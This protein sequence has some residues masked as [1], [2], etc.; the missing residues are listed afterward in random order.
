MEEF[1]PGQ[2]EAVETVLAGRDLFALFPTGAGKSLC[3]QLPALILPPPTLVISPLIALMR[4]QVA[5]L[6]ARGIGAVCLDSLQPPEVF[7]EGMAAVREGRARL[8]YVS[9]ERL[10]SRR[11][12]ALMA[13]CPPSLAVVDEAHCC[14]Q[15]GEGFRPA[16]A[17]IGAFIRA[18]ARRPVV[19][20]MTATADRRLR[21]GI[22]RSVGLRRPRLLRLPLIRENLRYAV[23]TTSDPT[24]EALRVA[25]AHE[26]ERGVV[27]CGTRARCE[28]LSAAL[29]GAGIAAERYHAGLDRGER[30]RVQEAF[31]AREVTV[32]AAT[33][34][35]GMGVDIPD[36]RWVLHDR[37]PESVTDYAQQSGRAGR[38]GLE[39][40]CILLVDPADLIRRSAAF[41]HA[42][43]ELKRLPLWRTSE[44]VRE[45]LRLRT[46]MAESRAMA[47][48]ALNG[49]CIPQQ[50]AAH[51]GAKARPCGLCSACVRRE[52]LG[53]RQ[54][55]AATPDIGR[56]TPD[57][58]RLWALDW[59][60]SAIAARLGTTPRDVLTDEGMAF[61]AEHRTLCPGTFRPEAEAALT[62]LLRRTG[63]S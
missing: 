54:P 29:R 13:D 5:S 24:A 15:W 30:T 2:R 56:E 33:S 43:I 57:S 18:L 36:I 4:D 20:A 40:D 63:S 42:R 41:A 17:E 23:R 61:A 25:Q 9:P 14:V 7:A 37:L 16:Y 8:V 34:A 49:R 35:F 58:I 11:F 44:R 39:S 3:Y 10:Q 32:L 51:F 52:A 27:F 38:D 60:R 19:C 31:T 45:G 47:D 12:L 6:T 62:R 55:L 59:Q 26:G 28:E 48:L 46:R 21:R 1:R 22:V 50:L 53:G